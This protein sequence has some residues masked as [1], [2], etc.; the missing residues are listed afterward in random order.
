MKA[1]TSKSSVGGS[2]SSESFVNPSRTGL[3]GFVGAAGGSVV[4]PAAVGFSLCT[5]FRC[6]LF[7]TYSNARTRATSKKTRLQP[8][9][10]GRIGTSGSKTMVQLPTGIQTKVTSSAWSHRTTDPPNRA[11]KNAF[12][13]LWLKD[14]SHPPTATRGVTIKRLTP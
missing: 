2:L 13:R 8:T 11:K 3:C 7:G 6:W 10:P 5:T 9:G 4:D 12:G 1:S 14:A